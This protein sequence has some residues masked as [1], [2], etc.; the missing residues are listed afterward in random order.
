M[1]AILGLDA[2]AVTAACAT[3]AQGQVVEAVNFNAPEQIV[4]AGHS[5]AVERAAAACK[6]LGAKRA[7]LLQVSAPFHC[8]LMQPAAERLAQRLSD[9]KFSSPVIPVV[10]NV[11][12]LCLAA[13]DE[14][15]DALVRQAASPVRWVATM[16]LL[17]AEG[18]NQVYECGPG[19]VLA[20][21]VKRCCDGLSGAAMADLAGIETALAAVKG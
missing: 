8:S 4:I 12:A 5:A 9:L 2:A 3:S 14:I 11:D 20:S 7:L 6:A 18:V 17:A 16:Q 1:A 13:P 21:L 19:K 15:R 10:N